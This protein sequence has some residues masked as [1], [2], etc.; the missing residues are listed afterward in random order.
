MAGI[1]FIEEKGGNFGHLLLR[2]V[3]LW[4][5]CKEED[6]SLIK[7]GSGYLLNEFFILVLSQSQ[8]LHYTGWMMSGEET[9]FRCII[10]P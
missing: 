7:L 6:C 5:F 10:V 8:S 3:L 2:F 9:P 1:E 4:E